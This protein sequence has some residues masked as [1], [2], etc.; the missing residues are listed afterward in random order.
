[1]AT[2][3]DTGFR[4]VED[5]VSAWTAP[6]SLLEPAF[7]DNRI[8]FGDNLPALKALSQEYANTIQ[9]IYIDPPYNTGKA[10][11]HYPDGRAHQQWLDA[12]KLRLELLW[13]LLREA[14][15]LVIQIDD[16]EF[17]RLY[18]LLADM[19]GEQ[20]LKTI[21]VKMAE[22]TG[23]KM[24]HAIT[25][26]SLPRLK[27]YVIL[28]GKSGIR[29]LHP[30]RIAK[31]T[32]DPE[33]RW[34]VRQTSPRAI[35]RL[36]AILT[37]PDRTPEDVQQADAICRPFC[38]ESLATVYRHEGVP[39]PTP[40]W[41]AENAWRI[42]RTCSTSATAKQ[43]A[44]QKRA[45]LPP[46][47]GAFS[48]ETVQRKLYIITAH[49]NMHSAQPRM[50][51]LFAADYLTLHPG[52]FW[53]DIKTTGLGEEGGVTFLK[54][55]KP[56]ALLKRII[57]MTTQPGDWVLDAY[58]GSGTTG[59]VAHKMGRQWLL[60]E[61]GPQCNTHIL[62]RLR[63]VVDGTDQTGVSKRLHW[64]GGGG[65]RYFQLTPTP[66]A[67]RPLSCRR[68]PMHAMAVLSPGPLETHP[69][70]QVDLPPPQP[71][72]AEVL[73][74]VEVCGVCRTDLHIAEGDLPPQRSPLIP[75]H[76]IVGTVVRAGIGVRRLR[77][78]D[79]VG[80][81]W[82]YAACTQCVYC[83]RG[84]ENLC[85][86]PRFTG[87]TEQGGYAEYVVA[88]A[89]FVYPLP[90]QLSS[91]EAAPL[92][93]AGIIGYR[94]LQRCRVRPG[95]RLGLY[96]FGGSAHIVIQIARHWG[97]EVYVV[98]RGQTHQ[99]LATRLGATW[100]GALTDPLPEKLHAAI[101]FAPAGSL[102][103]PALAALDRGGTLAL[104]GVHMTRIPALDYADALFHERT[105]CS[106]TANTR[107][108]GQALLHLAHSIPL[109]TQTEAYTLADA[110][111]ALTRMK[112]G[113][114][115]GAAVLRIGH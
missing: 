100:V 34:V 31:A 19:L 24:V 46:Q 30:E 52:D 28:V 90:P 27:E 42:V 98:S 16:N 74:R 60:I 66:L 108:D 111:T 68:K 35:H 75:G 89:D 79:R 82:L 33:Y 23:F 12:L 93:C 65:F 47:A 64:K 4:L 62:P 84:D 1:M 53:A 104:A 40:E 32:W 18:L 114:L 83:R 17:A 8:I 50:R 76:E 49:Y 106:V 72:R 59:A 57:G 41:L 54:G 3:T 11:P 81:A 63:A 58:A 101:L 91:V 112:N 105:L 67:Q 39:R 85:L 115:T 77:E 14:G 71:A 25:Q 94:A 86:R 97:C 20:N 73:L 37:N 13:A 70:Q 15:F 44:D 22:P 21:C 107:Q 55:K 7:F 109:H 43:R 87:Y 5:T 95:Q 69:L 56:E 10:L 26:G 96:G 80:V 48:I 78:G 88:P 29:N 99:A 51:L 45:T 36:K 113:Q 61:N 6:P 102:V 9:C 110:N 103:P 92:L 38:L 2:G